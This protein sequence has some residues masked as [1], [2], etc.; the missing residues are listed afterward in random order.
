MTGAR[1]WL[2]TGAGSGI[3]RAVAEAALARGDRV[4]A[5]GPDA[6]K[7]EHLVRAHPDHAV[8]QRLDVTRDDDV[9]AAVRVACARFDGVDV[10]VNCAGVGMLAAVEEATDEDVRALFEVNFFGTLRTVRAVVPLLRA[11]GGG[12]IINVSSIA[13]RVSAPLVAAYS[14]T[15]FAVEGLGAG[16]AAETRDFGIRVTTISPGSYATDFAASS[17][18]A[19]QSLDD[20][21]AVREAAFASVAGSPSGDPADLARAVLTIAESADPPLRFAAGQDSYEAIASDLRDQQDE[22]HR[23]GALSRSCGAVRTGTPRG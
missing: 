16:L 11:Q 5:T 21:D 13:G 19:S 22:L 23:W 7:I 9:A 1:R 12:R 10:L 20:Y 15:K 18:P 4:M 17:R 14:A 6:A 2:I 3:G 8:A